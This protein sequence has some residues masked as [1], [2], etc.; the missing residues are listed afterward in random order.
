MLATYK[1][2][3]SK[4]AATFEFFFW[5]VRVQALGAT[6]IV[7]D[8]SNPKTIK[9]DHIEV[10][11]RF[12]S[13]LEPGPALAGLKSRQGFDKSQVD[14]D[15]TTT[16]LSW[17]N[18]GNHFKRLQTVKPPMQCDYTVTIRQNRVT[19]KRRD[20]NV[21]AWYRFAEHI[22]AVLIDDYYVKPI[23]LH[24]R[25]ALYAGAK[26]NFGVCNGPMAILSLTEY[27]VT[28]IVNCE[29]AR[30]AQLRNG[31]GENARYPWMLDN[32]QFVW[33]EDTFDNLR[34]WFDQ[35]AQA[36]T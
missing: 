36:T 7:F 17:Y 13:I 11:K 34:R 8:V 30:D 21:E 5:M 23:H 4:Y 14:G 18:S 35:W 32:Q 15:F 24:D 9:F 3:G 16:F 31:Y 19:P 1:L 20:S 10:M 28:M 12:A 29:S 22:S 25:I 2:S 6:K 27:P 26:M 33:Q